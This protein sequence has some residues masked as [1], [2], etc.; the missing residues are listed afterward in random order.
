V[1]IN[2]AS[3][4]LLPSRKSRG[5]TEEAMFRKL[6]ATAGLLLAGVATATPA[7]AGP[8]HTGPNFT[9]QA[10]AHLVYPSTVTGIAGNVPFS[11]DTYQ[12]NAVQKWSASDPSGICEYQLYQDNGR[13]PAQLLYQGLKTSYNFKI[14]DPEESTGGYNV[15]FFALRVKDC[16]GNW[17]SNDPEQFPHDRYI[18]Q[19]NVLNSAVTR[20]QGAA[21]YT[22]SWAT[23]NCTC[24]VDGTTKHAQTAGASA[25][26]T[27]TGN[28]VGW[29]T[30][31]G[32]TRGSAKIYQD[33]VLKTTISTY[34][35]T[36][37]GAKVMWA[38]WFATTGT[39]KIKI[40]VVGTAG[41]PRV[42]VD[43]FL[44][45]PEF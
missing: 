15:L 35:A 21:T 32:P 16:A 8:D 9:L 38:N 4:K 22:G 44:V 12:T 34:S 30:E 33:G 1:Y 42:D 40:V 26:F 43:G 37:S 36:N 41:H 14:G 5:E 3:K 17:S 10:A 39:H 2:I 27:Y 24:F 7:S 20:D 13:G 45:D 23:A 6:C 28:V 18:N 11:Q 29:V 25:T 19:H 31:T